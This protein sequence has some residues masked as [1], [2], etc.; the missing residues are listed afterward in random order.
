M[1][2]MI[3]LL[4]DV[5]TAD[6]RPFQLQPTS[7]HSPP[8]TPHGP[9]A[10]G[11]ADAEREDREPVV[12]GAE[13][14]PRLMLVARGRGCAGPDSEPVRLARTINERSPHRPEQNLSSATPSS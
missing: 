10:P 1:R 9:V 13:V 2:R 5:A 12:V 7:S 14:E 8:K 3:P 6:T 11:V 4:D